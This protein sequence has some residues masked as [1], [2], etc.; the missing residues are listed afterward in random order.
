MTVEQLRTQYAA[1]LKHADERDG[2][3][4]VD[5]E[6]AHLRALLTALAAHFD[7]PEDLTCVDEGDALR[8]LYRLY[9]TASGQVLH[10]NVRVPRD[11]A[12]LPTVSDLWRGYEWH[13]R[14][15][16]DLFGVV[17]TEHP[18]LRRILTWE[19]FQGHPLRKDFQPDADDADW[20]IPEQTD[21]DIM[22][23]LQRD[24]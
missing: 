3:W 21:Q 12:Q 11:D 23:L 15:V 20:R 4:T 14:E 8:V 19:G 22:D 24:A 16:F 10:V 13:E 1:L 18:D 17:F 7:Y 6:A 2:L 5:V 9:A